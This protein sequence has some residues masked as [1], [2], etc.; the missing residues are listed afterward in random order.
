MLND[1]SVMLKLVL[2]AEGFLGG[3]EGYFWELN[4]FWGLN[5][6]GGC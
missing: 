4:D 1:F 5:D 2:E 3:A 6:L